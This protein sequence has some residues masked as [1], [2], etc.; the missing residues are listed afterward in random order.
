MAIVTLSRGTYGGVKQV[1]EC[2]SERLGYGLLTREELLT[3]C[4]QEYGAT[5]TQLESALMQRPGFLEGRGLRRLRYIACIQAALARRVQGDNMVYLGQAG[6]LLLK[7]VPHLLRVRVVANVE[8]RIAGVMQR[9]DFS[10]DRAIQYLR[11][12]DEERDNWVKWVYGVDYNDPTNFDLA[13][14]LARVSVAR[15]CSIVIDTVTQDFQT[16][17]EAQQVLD[18]LAIASEVRARMGLDPG[19]GDER[20]TV[21]AKAGVVTITADTRHLA[22][23]EKVKELARRIPGVTDARTAAEAR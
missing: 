4:A 16:S 5:P 6:H 11:E 14:N 20:I 23:A 15:A 8:H 7:G 22:E 19:I 9:T 17:P 12:M 1:A 10:R 18:D 21:E 3:A 2:L 13:V